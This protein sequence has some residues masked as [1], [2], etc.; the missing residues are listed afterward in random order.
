MKTDSKR[1]RVGKRLGQRECAEEN[2]LYKEKER[3]EGG[4]DYKESNGKT[5]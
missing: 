2:I 5:K 4:I 1:K 3:K